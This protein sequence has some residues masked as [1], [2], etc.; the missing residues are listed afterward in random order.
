MYALECAPDRIAHLEF[1]H[2]IRV[3]KWLVKWSDN[4]YWLLVVSALK[5]DEPGSGNNVLKELVK[6]RKFEDWTKVPFLIRDCLD[7]AGWRESKPFRMYS[8]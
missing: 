2:H 3:L 4:G 8:D 6:F 1:E 5:M 7:P